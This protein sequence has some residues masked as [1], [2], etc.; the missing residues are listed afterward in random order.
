MRTTL[1]FNHHHHQDLNKKPW[2]QIIMIY[3]LMIVFLFD[4]PLLISSQTCNLIKR[5]QEWRTMSYQSQMDYI[6]AV[7]CTIKNPSDLNPSSNWN[8]LDDFQYVH[9]TLQRQV[10]FVAQF[11]SCEFYISLL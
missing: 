11:L 8:R 5:R 10:H 2:I 4:L 6:N 9:S 7:K 1:I 3:A